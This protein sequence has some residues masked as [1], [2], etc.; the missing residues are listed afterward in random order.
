MDRQSA[1]AA[2]LAAEE[3]LANA[4]LTLDLATL[5]QLLHPDYTIL[6]PGGRLE[7]KAQV[8][9]SFAGGERHWDQARVDDME[10]RIY[11]ATAVVIGRWRAQGCNRGQ[12]FN[13][14]ARF[15]S[16]WLETSAGWRNLAYHATEIASDAG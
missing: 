15:L 13:Y 10:V 1:R 14:A 9:A 2:V 4:H 7:T 3:A 8:L 16:V 11:G 6:Q 5:N 12:V